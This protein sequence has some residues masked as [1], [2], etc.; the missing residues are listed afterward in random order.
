MIN[1]EQIEFSP[2]QKEKYGRNVK[3]HAIF[4]RHGE[5]GVSTVTAETALSETGRRTSIEF[6]RKLEKREAIKAYTSDTERTIETARLVVENSPTQR[7]MVQRVRKE[8]GFYYDKEG[9]FFRK[10]MEIK[11][12]TLGP[13]FNNLSEEEK[14]R[15]T[16][17]S[18]KRQIDYYLSF[19]D[20]RPDLK[21][22]SPVETA[23]MVARRVDIYIRMAERLYSG[24]DV[25]LINVSHDF[26]LSAFLKETLVREVEGKKVRGFKT[27]DEIGGPIEFNEGFEFLIQTDSERNKSVKIVFRNKEYQVDVERLKELV[28]IAKTLEESENKKGE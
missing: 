28:D 18:D 21:T 9:D 7:K 15:R 17:E 4:I 16:R 5:K 13:D 11:K 2:E 12:E 26:P 10:A 3:I 27:L 22:F 1:K 24:S 6:G 25:D 8:L 23:A 14:R 19:G 20:K